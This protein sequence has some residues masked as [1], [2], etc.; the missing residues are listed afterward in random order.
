MTTDILMHEIEYGY[1]EHENKE[2]TDSDREHVASMIG[3]GFREG[4]LV[5]FDHDTEQE[6]YG[7][8]K[9]NFK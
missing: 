8:W 4:E 5:T 3:D 6:I 2:M 7:W 9:I 1:K